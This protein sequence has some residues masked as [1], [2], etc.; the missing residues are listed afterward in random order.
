MS[1]MMGRLPTPFFVYMAELSN[2]RRAESSSRFLQK[3]P[4]A[5]M[6]PGTVL[7]KKYLGQWRPKYRG[8]KRQEPKAGDSSA[9]EG[10]HEE[11][12]PPGRLE[13]RGRV[14]SSA[15]RAPTRN[16]FSY[17]LKVTERSSLHLY[18]DASSS[19]NNVSCHIRGKS[20]MGAITSCPTLGL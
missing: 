19:S 20:D 2:I 10:G 3:A 5:T 18:A 11:G 12:C 9:E 4:I 8:N 1:S 16:A 6:Q 15:S 7:E 17:I 13:L 14:M